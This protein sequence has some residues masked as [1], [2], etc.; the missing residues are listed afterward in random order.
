MQWKTLFYATLLS[1]PLPAL[2]QQ[3]ANKITT[4]GRQIALLDENIKPEQVLIKPGTKVVTPDT[5]LIGKQRPTASMATVHQPVSQADDTSPKSYKPVPLVGQLA[6]YGN[7]N[8]YMV[9]YCASYI[10]NFGKRLVAVSNKGE[11]FS[12]I[13]S[14]LA[15]HQIPKELEYLA[16]IE[17][18]LNG[19]A[20][21]PVGAVGYWQFMSGTARLFGLTVNRHRDD[22]KNL[23][24]STEA[25]AK[26]LGYLYS[27]FDDWLLVVAAYNCGGGRLQDAIDRADGEK[28]FWAVKQYLPKET[29]NH[30]LAFVATATIMERLS[31]Y[32]EPGLPDNFDWTS[33]NYNGSSE[34]NSAKSGGSFER[35]LLKKFGIDEVKKMALVRIEKPVNLQVLASV[36]QTDPHLIGRWNYDYYEYSTH[37]KAGETYNLRI[38]KDKLDTYIAQKGYIQ[39]ASDKLNN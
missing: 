28:N 22:R 12:T 14:I 11:T 15:Q 1:F 27:K 35:P 36:L 30:V 23:Y 3:N 13:E 19:S 6:Y 20:R 17:S 39:N 18:A 21:S 38:P 10:N 16:V 4:D 29:Q 33:L 26:Y 5:L 2:A 9:N 8:A 34:S 37:Y 24:K 32:M 31:Q 25:A 7:M